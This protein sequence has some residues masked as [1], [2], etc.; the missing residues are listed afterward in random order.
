MAAQQIEDWNTSPED[1]LRVAL[2]SADVKQGNEVKKWNLNEDNALLKKKDTQYSVIEDNP[3]D[4]SPA[5][6]YE[7]KAPVV[8]SIV[9]TIE[10]TGTQTDTQGTI[11][12]VYSPSDSYAEKLI[13]TMTPENPTIHFI[14]YDDSNA[15]HFAETAIKATAFIINMTDDDESEL[16]DRLLDEHGDKSTLFL[17]DPLI[18]DKDSS[19]VQTFLEEQNLADN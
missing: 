7:D 9:P 16:L 6:E 15:Q 19:K 11:V 13:K 1:A 12:G 17:C 5:P 10:A 18:S 2:I 8:Q 14:R 4:V 3:Y